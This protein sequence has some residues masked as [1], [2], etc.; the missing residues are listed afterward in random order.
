MTYQ[1]AFSFDGRMASL[2][3]PD[4]LS[5]A[6]YLETFRRKVHLEPEKKLMLAVLEDA[7]ACFHK[8][9][10]ARDAR[11]R[12]MFHEAEVWIVE[13][14]NEGLFSFENVCE[15]LGFDP[16]YVRQGLMHWKET[17]LAVQPKV[18]IYRLTARRAN[19]TLVAPTFRKAGRKILKA[20]AC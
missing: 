13:D 1:A 11:R 14:S 20:A 3:Q 4:I 5:S 7:I 8:Y 12:R 10:L 6:Q 18:K 16:S 2:F 19:R 15:V 9:L 17:E